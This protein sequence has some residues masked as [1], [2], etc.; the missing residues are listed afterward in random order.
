[1]TFRDYMEQV[2]RDAREAIEEGAG[3]YDRWEDMNEALFIDD[4]VTGNGSGE[5][6]LRCTEGS[7][8]R[9]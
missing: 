5:L 7:R 8:R 4:D 6:L 2:E 9:E 1:M 3:W